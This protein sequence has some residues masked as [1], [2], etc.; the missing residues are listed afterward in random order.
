M[1]PFYN[2]GMVVIGLEM[3]VCVDAR[4]LVAGGEGGIFFEGLGRKK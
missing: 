3:G 1:Q 4:D 2:G